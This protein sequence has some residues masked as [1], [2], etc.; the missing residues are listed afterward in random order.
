[1]KI[2]ENYPGSFPK[3]ESITDL[4][5]EGMFIEYCGFSSERGEQVIKNLKNKFVLIHSNGWK[6]TF[7]DAE[8]RIEWFSEPSKKK[9]REVCLQQGINPDRF[10]IF[11]MEYGEFLTKVKETKVLNEEAKELLSVLKLNTPPKKGY[12]IAFIE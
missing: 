4:R 2:I 10:P 12:W 1:M 11:F 6:N 3:V 9:I 7:I 8:P 5:K